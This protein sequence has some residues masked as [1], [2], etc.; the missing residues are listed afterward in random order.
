MDGWNT[1]LSYWG[2]GLFSGPKMYVSGR[3][4]A[5]QRPFR[6]FLMLPT[7]NR[8]VPRFESKTVG[9]RIPYLED[10]P[11]TD[12]YVV[13]NH[14]LFLSPK[15]GVVGPFQMAVSWCINGGD[16]NHLQVLG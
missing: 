6:V 13:N 12:G 10:H 11:R 5:F 14:S 8:S 15:D 1:I 7:T 4:A 3:V 9:P 16:P 2:F